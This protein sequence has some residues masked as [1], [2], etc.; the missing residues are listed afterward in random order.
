RERHAAPD[1][2]SEGGLEEGRVETNAVVPELLADADV[3]REARLGLQPRVRKAGKEQV[4]ERRRAEAGAGAA[5]DSRAGLLD[6]ERQ[7][8][9]LG[10][11]LAEDVV[12]LHPYAGGHEEAVEEAELLLEQSRHRLGGRAE[13]ARA[14]HVGGLPP[15]LDAERACRPRADVEVVEPLHLATLDLEEP[16]EITHTEGD[17]LPC[18]PLLRNAQP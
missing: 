16:G 18:G 15:I 10:D 5:M 3:P 9:A 7:R 13:A 8:A 4:V 6:Q 14:L 1:Q 17:R 2:V 12:A 11:R